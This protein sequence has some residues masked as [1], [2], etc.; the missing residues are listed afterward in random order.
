MKLTTSLS[1]EFENEWWCTSAPLV[2]LCG[3]AESL[4]PLD[5]PVLML[6]RYLYSTQVVSSVGSHGCMLQPA[7]QR[8]CRADLLASLTVEPPTVLVSGGNRCRWKAD[9][10]VT[11]HCHSCCYKFEK[12]GPLCLFGCLTISLRFLY[13]YAPHNDVWVNDGPY[14]RRRSH[15]III[16]F[17]I[18]V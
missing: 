1:A 18:I 9:M 6:W 8:W 10:P 2:C 7:W 14:I 11:H 16:Y 17:N 13:R 3:M 4:Y 12:V 15:K 5:S